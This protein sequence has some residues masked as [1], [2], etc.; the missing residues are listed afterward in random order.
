MKLDLSRNLLPILLSIHVDGGIPP[1]ALLSVTVVIQEKLDK[2]VVHKLINR[3]TCIQ[4]ANP[5]MD[6]NLP[7]LVMAAI[8]RKI[9]IDR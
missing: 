6:L 7:D 8:D 2:L 4:P 1:A 3:S 9:A 5:Y